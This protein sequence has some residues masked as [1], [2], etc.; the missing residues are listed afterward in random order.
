[1][2]KTAPHRVHGTVEE[3]FTEEGWGRLRSPELDGLVFG[4]FSMIS[5]RAGFRDLRPGQAVTFAW[6]YGPQ[7]GCTFRADDIRADPEGEPVAPRPE[8]TP[9]AYQ[10]SLEIRWDHDDQPPPTP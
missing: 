4:H 7:D 2:T 6:E 1:M 5:S 10:S 9:G 3:W 8:S